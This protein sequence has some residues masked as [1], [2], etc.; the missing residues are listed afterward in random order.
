MNLPK[1][2]SYPKSINVRDEVYQIRLVKHVPGL[3]AEDFGLCDNDK[4]IIWLKKSQSPKGLLRT[5]IHELLHAI[6][7]EYNVKLRHKK[8]DVLEVAL[9]AL[10]SDNF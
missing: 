3:E 1:S 10:L 7:C 8:I 5:L 2:K 4:K 6:E 9:E